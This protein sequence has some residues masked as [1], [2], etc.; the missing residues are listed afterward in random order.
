MAIAGRVAKSEVWVSFGKIAE[1]SERSTSLVRTAAQRG[2]FGGA[3]SADGKRLNATHATVTAWMGR[4]YEHTKGAVGRRKK[5]AEEQAEEA[6]NP[7]EPQPAIY[8]VSDEA[9]ISK[10]SAAII[11]LTELGTPSDIH[12]WAKVRK[13]IA[14]AAT[15]EARRDQANGQLVPRALVERAVFG[16]LD[17]LNR[18]LL[19]DT[20]ATIAQQIGKG[21]PAERLLIEDRI[22]ALIKKAREDCG[23]LIGD[24]EE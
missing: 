18:R 17:A 8:D 23:R 6:L 12:R 9:M 19:E 2:E 16:Y 14:A 11:L 21:T 3:L 1:F 24:T 5:S 15:A 13:E 20:S 7:S 4:P 10:I 22:G